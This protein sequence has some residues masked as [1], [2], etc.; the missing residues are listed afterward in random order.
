MRCEPDSVIHA[1][2]ESFHRIVVVIGIVMAIAIAIAI[3]VV[4]AIAIANAIATVAV[5]KRNSFP[6]VILANAR[7]HP[8]SSRIYCKALKSCSTMPH[9]ERVALCREQ[10][11]VTLLSEPRCALTILWCSGGKLRA[12]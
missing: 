12:G 4:I 10:A 8:C 1:N 2:A 5:A 7:I 11:Q 9:G 6:L 3:A